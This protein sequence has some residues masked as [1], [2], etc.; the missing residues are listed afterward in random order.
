MSRP[1]IEKLD[2]SAVLRRLERE[3]AST[4]GY[5]SDR[6][7]A[8]RA[9]IPYATYLGFKRAADPTSPTVAHLVRLARYFRVPIDTFLTN[10]AEGAYTRE[11]IRFRLRLICGPKDRALG[12]SP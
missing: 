7:I 1:R 6:K 5:E 9:S 11:G 10:L 12:H 3:R 2:I 4:E 8:I